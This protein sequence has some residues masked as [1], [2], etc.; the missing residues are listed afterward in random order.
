MET[1]I[2]PR[3]LALLLNTRPAAIVSVPLNPELLPLSQRVPGPRLVKPWVLLSG[4]LMVQALLPVLFNGQ[5]VIVGVELE[6][7]VRVLLPPMVQFC[8]I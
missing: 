4:T 7:S 8:P 1:L 2:A 6:L 3:P 5:Q